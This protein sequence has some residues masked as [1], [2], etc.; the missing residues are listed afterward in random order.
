MIA[1][2]TLVSKLEM[3]SPEIAKVMLDKNVR[4]RRVRV[5]SVKRWERAMRSGE[6]KVS[7]QGIIFAK[8]GNLLDGQH[9]LMA[10]IETGATLP[11]YVTYG[12]DPDIFGVLDCGAIRNFSDR[13]GLPRRVAEAL[14]VASEIY[15]G[16]YGEAVTVETALKVI[17][18]ALI[19][20]IEDIAADNPRSVKGVTQAA[21]VSAV[22]ARALQGNKQWVRTTFYNMARL[23]FSSLDQAPSI[24]LRSCIAGGVN[25]YGSRGRIG[26]FAKAWNAFDYEGRDR[27]RI[28]VRDVE[29]QINE[30]RAVVDSLRK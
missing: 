2:D 1:T 10:L 8:D 16:L 26:A 12:A 18:Q 15:C 14:R 17:P 24:F 3:I 21:V 5:N 9:R 4:N 23:E 25:Q 13:T 11:F 22:A 28:P 20:E 29:G 30:Y 27:T 19:D 6:W 7:P